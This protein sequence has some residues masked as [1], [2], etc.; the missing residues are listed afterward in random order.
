MAF[1]IFRFIV[2]PLTAL[3]SITGALAGYCP[4]TGTSTTSSEIGSLL[5][6]CDPTSSVFCLSWCCASNTYACLAA[7]PISSCAGRKSQLGALASMS[8]CAV[9]LPTPHD[10]KVVN[11]STLPLKKLHIFTMVCYFQARLGETFASY[12]QPCSLPMQPLMTQPSV[13]NYSRD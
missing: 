13:A 9:Q 12:K 3:W 2:F 6:E 1:R 8:V 4:T 5:I 7:T 10:H 11:T